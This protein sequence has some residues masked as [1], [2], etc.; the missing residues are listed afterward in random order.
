[1]SSVGFYRAD[2]P[3]VVPTTKSDDPIYEYACRKGNY[4]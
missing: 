3:L 4:A 2:R 1:M